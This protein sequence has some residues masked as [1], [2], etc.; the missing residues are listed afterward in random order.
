MN[1]LLVTQWRPGAAGF[2]VRIQPAARLKT[3]RSLHLLAV[4]RLAVAAASFEQLAST[5]RCLQGA[6]SAL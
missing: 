4:E 2:L 6:L 5:L 3:A 1:H